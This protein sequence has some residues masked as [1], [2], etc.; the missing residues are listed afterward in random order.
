MLRII[1]QHSEYV[2][3]YGDLWQQPLTRD[4][5]LVR[6]MCEARRTSHIRDGRPAVFHGWDPDT[7]KQV[8]ITTS[9]VETHEITRPHIERG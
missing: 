9:P 4:S 3:V 2:Y 6:I 8:V 5:E 1:T 7:R